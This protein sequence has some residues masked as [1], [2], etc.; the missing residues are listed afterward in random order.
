MDE[1]SQELHV[2]AQIFVFANKWRSTALKDLALHKLRRE[3]CEYHILEDEGIE[4]VNL[5][6]YCF[7]TNISGNDMDPEND[8]DAITALLWNCK[9]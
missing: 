3:I 9:N 8:T 7:D 6:K 1:V 4:V 2:H 5:R